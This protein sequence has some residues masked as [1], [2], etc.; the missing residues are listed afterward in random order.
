MI[1]MCE[2]ERI[3]LLRQVM[4][5]SLENAKQWLDG[6]KLLIK[7]KKLAG[8]RENYSRKQ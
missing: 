2:D 7:R 6:A 3:S 1:K 8:L 5:Y 4:E